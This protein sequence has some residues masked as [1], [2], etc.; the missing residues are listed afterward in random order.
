MR[1]RVDECH[2]LLLAPPGSSDGLISG[3][4]P[5]VEGHDGCRKRL[6]ILVDWS[7]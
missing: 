2:G 1:I 4:F 3:K 5:I 7:S 6:I